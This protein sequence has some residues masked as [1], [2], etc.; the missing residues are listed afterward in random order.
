MIHKLE[1]IELFDFPLISKV[2]VD[3]SSNQ[4]LSIPSEACFTYILNGNY[5]KLNINE[6]TITFNNGQVILSMCGLTLGK[7]ISRQKNG[8]LKAIIIHFHPD[9]IR[10][11]YEIGKPPFWKELETPVTRFLVQMETTLLIEHFV[12]GIKNLFEH[13]IACKKEFLALKLKELIFLLMQGESSFE[14][15]QIMKS[16]F[17]ERTFNFKEIIEAHILSPFSLESFAE[18]T[19]MS[20]SS[21]KRAF[22]KIYNDTPANYILNRKLE[23]VAKML[24]VSEKSI[25]EICYDSGFSTPSHLT[26]VFKTKFNLSPSKY[27]LNFTDK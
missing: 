18:F 6:D 4:Q 27:R 17:S 25:S 3:T 22:K 2:D 21:F 8:R 11:I 20:L 15:K 5:L 26:K 7:L 13:N 12:Q 16:L 9:I 19:N 10:K 14:V 1:T 23:H 24:V